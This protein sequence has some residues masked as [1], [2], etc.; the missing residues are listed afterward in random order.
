MLIKSVWHP[1]KQATR[2]LP[3]NFERA[4]ELA[5][6]PPPKSLGNAESVSLYFALENSHE[7]FLDVRQTDDW[8]NVEDDSIF[9]E[10]PAKCDTVP[11]EEVI[12]LRNRPGFPEEYS[13]RNEMIEDG[14]VSERGSDWNVM[15]HLEEALGGTDADKQRNFIS[16][17]QD[18]DSVLKDTSALKLGEKEEE[19]LA[20]L[21]VSGL[22][23]PVQPGPVAVSQAADTRTD[24]V[25]KRSGD[26]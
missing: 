20:L 8:P 26:L 9:Y 6:Q 2:A 15:D 11:L 5:T 22:P 17:G 25:G 24:A 16:K 23:K 12:A 19:L 1:A 3:S 21:G 10:F 13:S 18:Q 7:A 4:E 14:E